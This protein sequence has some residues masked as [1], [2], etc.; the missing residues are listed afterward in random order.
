VTQSQLDHVEFDLKHPPP[1][2]TRKQAAWA[3]LVTE[4]TVD[5]WRKSGKLPGSFVV[6]DSRRVLI[7]SRSVLALLA[8]LALLVV[9]ATIEGIDLMLPGHDFGVIPGFAHH[10]EVPLD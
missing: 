1:H 5:R 8:L 6:R 4:R 9:L 7:P 10:L 2:V 3:L